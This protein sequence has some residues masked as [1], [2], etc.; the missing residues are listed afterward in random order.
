MLKPGIIHLA[1]QTGY[2]I[3]PATCSY[4]R[5]KQFG[6]WDGFMLPRPFTRALIRA[7]QPFRVDA[8]PSD[9]LEPYRL[10]LEK[11]LKDLTD[12]TDRDFEA[13]WPTARSHA[14]YGL[15]PV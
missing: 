10:R 6:S 1:A 4:A 2:P 9:D 5:Y 8:S 11:I 12:E 15:A 13:L 7:A 14:P 3:L